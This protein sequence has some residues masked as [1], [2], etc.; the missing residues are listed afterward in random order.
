M[1]KLTD[2]Q[3]E[4]LRFIADHQEKR[5]VP[6]TLEEIRDHFHWR[7]IGTVQDH[8]RG[9]AR[10]G[11]LKRGRG[12]RRLEVLRD[13]E[14]VFP[15]DD[16]TWTPSYQER[17]RASGRV[18]LI[19]V[20][21]EVAAGSPILAVENVEEEWFL[22]RKLLRG[23]DNFLLRV[24]GESMTGAHI[25]DGDYLLIRPQAVAE[26][27]EIVVALAGDEVTTKRFY[28]H[29]DRIELRPENP[30]FDTIVY[31]RGDEEVEIIGKVVGVLRKYR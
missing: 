16:G 18:S 9:L 26:N 6:P 14:S 2:R 8:L 10:K 11:Y 27:G 21:G 15:D 3:R 7:A 12:A 31:R 5:G 24:K 17:R 1:D 25:R 20:V 19:P 4:V 22:D 30:A 29:R 28:R 13:P 23:D